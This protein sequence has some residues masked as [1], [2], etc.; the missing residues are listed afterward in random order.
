MALEGEFSEEG[1]AAIAGDDNMQ[2]ALAKSHGRKDRSVR[3]ATDV[4]KD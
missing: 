2:M 3:H 1:L 4:V